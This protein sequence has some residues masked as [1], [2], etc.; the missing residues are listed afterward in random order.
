M[1]GDSFSLSKFSDPHEQRRPSRA[2]RRTQLATQVRDFVSRPRHYAR[3]QFA[4][5]IAGQERSARRRAELQELLG[6]GGRD[7]RLGGQQLPPNNLFYY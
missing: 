7:R 3:D 4:S 2:G 5:L 1:L 6:V